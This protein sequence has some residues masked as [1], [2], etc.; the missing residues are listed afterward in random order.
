MLRFLK[1][2]SWKKFS[3][4]FPLNV[5]NGNTVATVKVLSESLT[6]Y[7]AKTTS[8]QARKQIA[9]LRWAPEV[10][11]E[12]RVQHWTMGKRLHNAFPGK[13]AIFKICK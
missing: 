1:G 11:P 6:N 13:Y 3:R 2:P 8:I 10:A 5:Q 12:W 7:E 9:M 4:C